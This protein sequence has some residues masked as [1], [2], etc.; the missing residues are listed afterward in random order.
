MSCPV[1]ISLVIGLIIIFLFRC[2][3]VVTALI[4]LMFTM[5]YRGDSRLSQPCLKIKKTTT[6]CV[7]FFALHLFLT[8]HY[9]LASS[10]LRL[11]LLAYH[12]SLTAYSYARKFNLLTDRTFDVYSVLKCSLTSDWLVDNIN[13]DMTRNAMLI[14]VSVPQSLLPH[15]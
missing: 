4:L 7:T 9:D 13:P 14:D 5:W 15:P 6:K 11:Y 3:L 8:I 12:P 2:T 1:K 10:H